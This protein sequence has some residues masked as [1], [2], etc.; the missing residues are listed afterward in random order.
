MLVF[1][2]YSQALL[3]QKPEQ[4]A[5]LLTFV[6]TVARLARDHPGTVWAI[7]K[8][9]IQANVI[10]DLTICWSKLDQEVWAVSM[11]K[12]AQGSGPTPLLQKRTSK[13]S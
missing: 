13:L 9:G 11:V 2:T 3:V 12:A 1:C 5:D 6:G 10:A 7:Y 8:Q 4:G